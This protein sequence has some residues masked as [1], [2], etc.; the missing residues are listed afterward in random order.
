MQTLKRPLH[1]L[2]TIEVRWLQ[3]GIWAML[4]LW[5][6]ALTLSRLDAFQI[7]AYNDDAIYVVLAR[8]LNDAGHYGLINAPGEHPE[9]A[10]FPCGFPK[11]TE[12]ICWV[13]VQEGRRQPRFALKNAVDW[14]L[15]AP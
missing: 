11:R 3:I 4:I 1:K 12:P 7:G 6:T 5:T 14:W 10:P 8:S 9:P 15:S 13:P 2:R